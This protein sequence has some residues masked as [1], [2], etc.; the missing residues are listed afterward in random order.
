MKKIL[1]I[2][3][4]LFLFVGCSDDLPSATVVQF[5]D[6]GDTIAVYR[7]CSVWDVDDG[8]VSFYDESRNYITISG[9][10]IVKR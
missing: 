10:F 9:R 8:T 7:N 1:A 6:R 3:A 5:N 2:L 4:L